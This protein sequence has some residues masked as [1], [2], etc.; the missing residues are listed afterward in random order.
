MTMIRQS[1]VRGTVLFPSPKVSKKIQ[2]TKNTASRV[3]LWNEQ[4][5]DRGDSSRVWLVSE[6]TIDASESQVA[7]WYSYAFIPIPSET[8]ANHCEGGSPVRVARPQ[9]T[10]FRFKQ[11][12]VLLECQKSSDSVH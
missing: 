6:G 2:N 4:K 1:F 7:K 3:Y 11:T 5:H 10:A 9:P 12:L 8:V